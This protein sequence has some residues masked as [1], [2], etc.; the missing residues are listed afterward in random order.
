MPQLKKDT[1]DYWLISRLLPTKTKL[2]EIP[3]LLTENISK[4]KSKSPTNIWSGSTKEEPPSLREK[5][6]WENRDAMPTNFS[7]NLW[8]NMMKLWKLSLS[9]EKT[10]PESLRNTVEK[11]L[12]LNLATFQWKSR[13]MLTSSMNKPCK[14]SLNWLMMIIQLVPLMPKLVNTMKKQEI[15]KKEP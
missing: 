9:S 6:I 15:T 5:K 1:E 12:S 10:S 2:L 8:K 4:T 14:N 13:P 7:L 11:P 3:P